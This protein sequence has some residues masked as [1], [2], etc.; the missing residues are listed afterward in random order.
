MLLGVHPGCGRRKECSS[1]FLAKDKADVDL[2]R[3]LVYR[4][5][6]KS[7]IPRNFGALYRDAILRVG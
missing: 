2:S 4:V 6:L 7:P 1:A 3:D 5:R